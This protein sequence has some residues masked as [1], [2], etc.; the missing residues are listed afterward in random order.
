MRDGVYD[1]LTH[2]T[3]APITGRIRKIFSHVLVG[4]DDGLPRLSEVNL[5]SVST[6]D[7]SLLKSRIGQLGPERMREVDEALRFA[8]GL[9][10]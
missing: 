7:K 9:D 8:L 6:I 5:D 10:D 3:I 2:V 4:P 1:Y